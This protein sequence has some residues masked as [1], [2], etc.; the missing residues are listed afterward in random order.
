MKCYKGAV[1]F[2]DMLG[3][4]ALT[5]GRVKLTSEACEPWEVD[6]AKPSPHQILAAR[7]LMK[8]R[9]VLIEAG[10]TFPAV[11]IA[12]LSDCAFL[13][14][15][16]VG[17]VTDCGRLLLEESVAQGLLVRGGLAYGDIVEPDRTRKSL[18][19]FVAGD[20]VTRAATYETAGKGM[21]VFTDVETAA[22]VM[23]ARSGEC[24]RELRNPLDGKSVDEWCW[25]L[26]NRKL[27]DERRAAVVRDSLGGAALRLAMLWRSPKY[28]WNASSDEGRAQLALAAEAVS[29]ALFQLAKQDNNYKFKA[30]QFEQQSKRSDKAVTRLTD[31]YQR[32]LL[33]LYPR[34][35]K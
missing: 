30:A 15:E 8:L 33:R 4:S 24:F 19:A 29:E 27:D 18:G 12:Q 7:L 21:R 16:D 14:S 28:E 23:E 20:A 25:Y 34:A 26:P 31:E 22:E 35:N 5:R 32:E 11:K 10:K 13:W 6:F 2:I 17:A 1:L 9:A 3:F